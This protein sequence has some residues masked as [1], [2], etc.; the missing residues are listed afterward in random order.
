ML[1]PLARLCS[2]GAAK[3]RLLLLADERVTSTGSGGHVLWP[4]A[5]HPGTIRD[6][7]DLDESTNSFGTR[8]NALRFREAIRLVATLENLHDCPR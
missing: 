1:S 3:L 5:D 7:G 4:L 2:A 6:M 8:P